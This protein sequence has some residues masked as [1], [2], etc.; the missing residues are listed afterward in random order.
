MNVWLEGSMA[1]LTFIAQGMSL[2]A[3]LRKKAAVLA[4]ISFALAAPTKAQTHDPPAPL[5]QN[6]GRASVGTLTLI[7]ENDLFYN[8]DRHYTNG[9][10][11]TW[12]TA[13]DAVPSWAMRWAQWLPFV[14]PGAHVRGV[15]SLGQT[16]YTPSDISLNDPPPGERPYAGWLRG[17]MGLI[18]ENGVH[19]DQI[20]LTLGVI[21]PLSLAEPAQK[22]VHRITDAP[23]PKGWDTQLHNEPGVV[24]TYQRS[25]RQETFQQSGFQVDVTPHVGGAAGNVSTYL[26]SGVTIRAGW[27]LPDDFGPPRIQPSLPGSGFFEA[28]SGQPVGFYGF[29]GLS[30]R[31]VARNIF[32]DGNSFRSSRKV[33]R[34][35]FVSDIQIG[36]AANL[37]D[38]R[39]TYTHVFRSREFKTQDEGDEYGAIAV[40]WQF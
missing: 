29:M 25:W 1:Y 11:A 14:E 4:A 7:L 20:Q 19:M 26:D 24:L 8:L 28:H 13:R 9:V 6:Q 10:E 15:F 27:L 2:F 17:S 39:I 5:N 22:L 16:M 38:A 18:T 36:V 32:L 33:D 40:T 31:Y 37:A 12:T 30:G 35:N 3:V 34:K 23:E 21:G